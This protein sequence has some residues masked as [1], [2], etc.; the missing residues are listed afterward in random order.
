MK[1]F[2]GI[3]ESA[4]PVQGTSAT[5]IEVDGGDKPAAVVEPVV[6]YIA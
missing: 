2:Q 5:T 1:V 4:R 6:R 3:E